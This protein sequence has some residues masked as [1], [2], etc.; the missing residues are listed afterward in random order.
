MSFWNAM[1]IGASA[2][3]AQRVRLDV[4]SNNI[5]NAETTR[6]ETGAPYK[7]KDVVFRPDGQDNFLPALVAANRKTE[8]HPGMQMGGVRVAQ[9]IE[10]Q[11]AG[12]RVYDPTHPDADAE[13]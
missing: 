6:T 3:A 5:A 8:T 12:P 11:E 9:I 4:I 7:R 10:D 1:R 2:L 13:G